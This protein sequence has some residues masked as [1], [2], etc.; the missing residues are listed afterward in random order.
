[1]DRPSLGAIGLLVV[2]LCLLPPL[3]G[4]STLKV[5]DGRV[6]EVSLEENRLTLIYRHPVSLEEEK[7]V[8]E[9]DK[10]TGFS[11]AV[12]LEDLKKGE[13][14]SVDY[15][16]ESD[17]KARAVLIKRVPIRGIPKDISR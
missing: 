16:E 2:T 14:L 15:E 12:R 8:F 5:V 6:D 17:A 4:A 11:E 13:P 7:L 3:G 10:E 9:V 1:M